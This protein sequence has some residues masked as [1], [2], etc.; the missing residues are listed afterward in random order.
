VPQIVGCAVS[1][2]RNTFTS[3]SPYQRPPSIGRMLTTQ[4]RNRPGPRQPSVIVKSWRNVVGFSRRNAA[5]RMPA[6]LAIS[7]SRV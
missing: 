6:S 4:P 2:S 5:C 7:G 1:P 3:P